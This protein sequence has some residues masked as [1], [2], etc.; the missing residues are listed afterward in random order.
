MKILEAKIQFDQ[1]VK[2]KRIA[3][4]VDFTSNTVKPYSDVRAI[5]A[6]TQP[7]WGYTVI[8]SDDT[9]NIDLLKRVAGKGNQEDDSVEFPGWEKRYR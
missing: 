7:M 2:I 3:V 8:S 4:L 9:P 6:T 1:D 5:V